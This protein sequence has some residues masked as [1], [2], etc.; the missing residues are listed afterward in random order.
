MRSIV[1]FKRAFFRL[2]RL[3]SGIQEQSNRESSLS[4]VA[5]VPLH[6]HDFLGDDYT[7]FCCNEA[8][9]APCAR[10]CLLITVRD[11]HPAT[12]GHVEASQLAMLVD[13][14]DKADVVGKD[15]DV[16]CWWDCNSNFKLKEGNQVL[17]KRES[18]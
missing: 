5:I 3:F 12:C 9:N 11:T 6:K 15:I 14:S 1:Y 16:V 7:L 8:Q 17:V 13:N 4:P 10:V 18:S 2:R